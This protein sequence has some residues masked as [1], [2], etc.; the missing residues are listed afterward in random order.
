MRK[1]SIPW[2]GG[3]IDATSGI[4]THTMFTDD[5]IVL[6][7]AI[8]VFSTLFGNIDTVTFY[9]EKLYFKIQVY[10]LQIK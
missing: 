7:I 10:G 5:M 1:L 6:K 3:G 2:S 9:L 4:A 8:R